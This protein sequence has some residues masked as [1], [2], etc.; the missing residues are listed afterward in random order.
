[1]CTHGLWLDRGSNRHSELESI[2]Q[3]CTEWSEEQVCEERR[4]EGM[5]SRGNQSYVVCCSLVGF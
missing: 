4:G 2:Q 1:M 5:G 3:I